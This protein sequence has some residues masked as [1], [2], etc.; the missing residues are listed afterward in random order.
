M[1]DTTAVIVGLIIGCI[2]LAVKSLIDAHKAKRRAMIQ[3]DMID[4]RL[5]VIKIEGMPDLPMGK[6]VRNE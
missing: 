5:G 6:D 3:R 4:L 2:P 1:N